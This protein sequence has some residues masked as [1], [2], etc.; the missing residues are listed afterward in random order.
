MFQMVVERLFLP[1]LSKI[2]DNDKKLSAIAITHLLCDPESMIT[3]IYFNQL[4][5]IL[6]QALLQLFQSCNELQI[7]SANER[8]KQ[9]QEQEEEDLIVGLDDTPGKFH[10]RKSF[11]QLD[12]VKI[13][14]RHFHDW[15]LRI[16]LRRI[17]L[18]QVFPMQDF[19]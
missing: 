9:A 10:F 6:L 8:K 7:M 4:W 5:L 2:D 3:G 13:I 17:Y 16:K 18:V 15:H 14:H 12:F 1:E 19:I 11:M